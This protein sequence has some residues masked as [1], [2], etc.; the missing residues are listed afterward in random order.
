MSATSHVERPRRVTISSVPYLPGLDGLRAL[1]VIAVMIY[2]ADPSWLPGGFLG[3]EVFFVI[4]GYLITLLLMAERERDGRINLGAFWMRRAR[5]LLPALFA[6]MVALSIWTTIAKPEALGKVRGDL[7]AGFFYVSNWFQIWVG[8]GYASSGDFAPLRHLWSLAVEEQFYLLWPI[9]MALVLRGGTRRVARPVLW[10]LGIVAVVTL[11]S[12]IAVHGGPIGECSVTP[13][14]YWTLG[15]RCIAKA[16]TL[17]LSTITRSTGLLLGAAM[18]MLWRPVAVMRGPMARRGL[19]L[20]L[21]ALLGL[22]GLALAA[23]RYHFVIDDQVAEATVADTGLFRGGFVLT[24]LATVAVIAAIAHRRSLTGRLLG[25]SPLLW[26]GTRSYGL[27]LYH[28]PIYQIIRGV[29]GRALS[30]WQFVF[31]MLLTVVVAEASYRF[32]ETPI[33][34]GDLAER[35]RRF[36]RRAAAGPRRIAGVAATLVVV[37]SLVSGVRVATADLELNEIEQSI[38]VGSSSVTDISELLADAPVT[39]TTVAEPAPDPTAGE[40]VDASADETVDATSETT[41]TAPPISVAPKREPI[42][43]LA[44]GDSVM[45]GAAPILAERGYTVNAQ[46]SRQMKD[47]VPFMQQL[48]DASVFGQAVVVH[49]GTNGYFSEETLDA[50]L[51]PLSEVPVIMLTVRGDLAWRDHNN[52]ILKARDAEADDNLIVIDWEAESRNCVGECF[53]GDGIHLAADGQVFYANLIR[54]VT[55]Q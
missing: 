3:V 17:Y 2:H 33:R 21:V 35:W 36:R 15:D 40:T 11:V 8:A 34:R 27:Y 9:V 44:I 1:A 13:E 18:A 53:A 52:D 38:L 19:L 54:D 31:A 4:S 6:V 28:W 51:E 24:G 16:D 14:A 37:L 10:M 41:T 48:R 39:A 45:L 47:T 29:A 43:Y 23:V 50:F 25:A 30:L 7:I 32:L 55:G 5:R 12:S 42:P 46:Q 20:D 22:V 26:V 49:L